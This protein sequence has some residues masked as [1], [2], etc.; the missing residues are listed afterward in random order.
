MLEASEKGDAKAEE[1]AIA[2]MT[3]CGFHDS[4]GQRVS[5][6]TDTL[7][8]LKGRMS[9]DPSEHSRRT[10]REAK[11]RQ[12]RNRDLM[13]NGPDAPTTANDRARINLIFADA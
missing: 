10:S 8:E 3:A 2:I 13:L 1:A 5:K 12:K 4:V 7:Q 6:I 11:R 9:T